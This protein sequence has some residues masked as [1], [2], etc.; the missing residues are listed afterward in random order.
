MTKLPWV[1]VTLDKDLKRILGTDGPGGVDIVGFSYSITRDMAPIYTL[2]SP[3]PPRKRGAAG[4]FLFSGQP[5]YDKFN[6]VIKVEDGRILYEAHDC[7]CLDEGDSLQRR[8]Y[9]PGEQITWAGTLP[10]LPLS[11][12]GNANPR[13]FSP[14]CWT[15]SK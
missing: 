5:V 11:F 4:T 2:G 15:Y 10:P 14:R 9:L 12:M 1:V 13:M 7:E 8:D 6:L 3:P